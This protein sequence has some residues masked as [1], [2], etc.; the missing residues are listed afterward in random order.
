MPQRAGHCAV[1]DYETPLKRITVCALFG[2]D[3]VDGDAV[4]A[5]ACVGDGGQIRFDNIA[6]LR[7]HGRAVI[8]R[9]LDARWRIARKRL[10]G[11]VVRAAVPWIAGVPAIYLPHPQIFRSEELR[12]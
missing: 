1:L 2:Y 4:H 6:R 11:A 10:Q 9:I 5:L 7:R 3:A 12:V 8:Q